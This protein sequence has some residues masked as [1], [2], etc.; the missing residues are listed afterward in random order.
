MPPASTSNKSMP[1]LA[2][3]SSRRFA[4][5]SL[6]VL[7]AVMEITYLT[8]EH[9][10]NPNYGFSLDDSWIHAVFAR[11][12]ATG[13]GYTFNPHETVSAST[14]PLYTFLL[15]GWYLLA[16]EVIWGAKLM[17]I[18]GLAVATMFLYLATERIAGKIA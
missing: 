18:L 1:A 10:M 12:L 17:G 5:I 6:V 3:I 14:A 7:L 11:N 13:H 16:G 4:L 15:A 8:A 9:R 2:L